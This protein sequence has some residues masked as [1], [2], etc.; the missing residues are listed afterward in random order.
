MNVRNVVIDAQATCGKTAIVTGVRPKYKYV[1]GK[2]TTEQDGYAIACVLPDRGYD[3]LVVSVPDI[4]EGLAQL[5][6]NPTVQF[7]GLTM[8]I[9]GRPDDL[10]VAARASA[11]RIIDSKGKA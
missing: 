10:R 1:D 6:G 5:H 2:R 7:D 3:D 11:V 4:P 8:S 9:Y